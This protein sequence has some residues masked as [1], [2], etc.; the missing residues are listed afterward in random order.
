MILAEI[1]LLGV[2]EDGPQRDVVATLIETLASIHGHLAIVEPR[3]TAG[4]HLEHLADALVLAPRFHGVVIGVDA[5]GL[6]R[7]G[8][9]R[10]LSERCR[11]PDVSLWAVAE[12]AIEEWMMADAEAL[13]RALTRLFGA[14]NI[15]NARRPGRSRAEGTAK[16]RLRQWVEAL[17]GEPVLQGGVEYAADVAREIDPARVGA[18]RNRDFARFLEELPQ[19]LTRCAAG[20]R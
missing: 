1:E 3:L 5:A 15:R 14:R 6:S 20:S 7:Q 2:F 13:P 4:C 9:I 19:F 16:S 12:P 10:K 8:K 18:A 17:L 11:I